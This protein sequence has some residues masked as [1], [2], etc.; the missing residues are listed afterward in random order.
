MNLT[1]VS[2]DPSKVPDGADGVYRS[3]NRTIALNED[4]PEYAVHEFA[5]S[6]RPVDQVKKIDD[7]KDGHSNLF[8]NSSTQED[9][10][11]DDSEEM[12]ARFMSL[13]YMLEK[14]GINMNRKFTPKDVQDLLNMFTNKLIL[15][16]PNGS[17]TFSTDGKLLKSGIKGNI[18]PGESS[19]ERDIDYRIRDTIGRYNLN[20]SAEILSNVASIEKKLPQLGR[21]GMKFEGPDDIHTQTES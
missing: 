2:I 10:Y 20:V 16:T 9:T 6:T 17:S 21:L 13:R 8:L 11:T 3:L 4:N 12:Y 18:N 1:T 5:H 7:I 15:K 19:I 14:M